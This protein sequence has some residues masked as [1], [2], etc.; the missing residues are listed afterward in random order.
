MM[1]PSLILARE[2]FRISSTPGDKGAGIEV[3]MAGTAGFAGAGSCAVTAGAKQVY[4]A[5]VAITETAGG[6]IGV[7]ITSVFPD[8]ATLPE[9]SPGVKSAGGVSGV[10]IA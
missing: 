3:V 2:S 6:K 8:N 4:K 1:T 5:M 9:G 10:L 7:F